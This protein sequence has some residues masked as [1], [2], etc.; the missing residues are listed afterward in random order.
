MPLA[1]CS[2]A[3]ERSL[4]VYSE[5]RWPVNSIE[6]RMCREPRARRSDMFQRDL[7]SAD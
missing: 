5:A 4:E 6:P 1:S 3:I 7:F 2:K